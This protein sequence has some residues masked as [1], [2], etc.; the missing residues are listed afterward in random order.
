MVRTLKK[1][2]M[3]LYQHIPM[4]TKKGGPFGESFRQGHLGGRGAL[5]LLL[6]AVVVAMTSCCTGWCEAKNQIPFESESIPETRNNLDASTV[7]GGPGEEATQ[8]DALMAAGQ[9][10]QLGGRHSSTPE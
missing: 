1:I 7:R 10:H 2:V 6:E 8:Q 3:S 4:G 9:P 5:S